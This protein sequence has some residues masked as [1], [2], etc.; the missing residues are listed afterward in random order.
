[1]LNSALSTAHIHRH[2]THTKPR[3]SDLSRSAGFPA[4]FCAA[5]IIHVCVQ[6]YT[7]LC[8]QTRVLV[9]TLYECLHKSSDDMYSNRRMQKEIVEKDPSSTRKYKV[10]FFFY[11][12]SSPRAQVIPYGLNS[13]PMLLWAT[14]NTCQR[15]ECFYLGRFLFIVCGSLFSDRAML[16]SRRRRRW[17]LKT[18]FSMVIED[19]MSLKLWACLFF[20]LMYNRVVG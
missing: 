15:R 20:W 3:D 11:V 9:C 1:M 12:M 8:H 19:V 7:H 16:F 2:G 10:V 6:L 18:S 4:L 5:L 17:K 13:A 14:V